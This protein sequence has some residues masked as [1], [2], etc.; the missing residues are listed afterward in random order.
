ME[1]G[2]LLNYAIWATAL[3]GGGFLLHKLYFSKS[4]FAKTISKSGNYGSGVENLME[5]DAPF[6]KAWSSSVK[7]GQ[8][9]FVYEG[10]THDT[11]GGRVTK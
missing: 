6:L 11:K 4:A 8:A 5:F 10:K 2:K 9:T 1:K 7:K 3:V